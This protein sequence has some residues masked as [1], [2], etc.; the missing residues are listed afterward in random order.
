M[1]DAIEY[2]MPIPEFE[3]YYCSDNGKAYS[4]K[5]KGGRGKIDPSFDKLH[6]L[7]YV[8]GKDGYKKKGNFIKNG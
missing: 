8:I 5:V 3:G 7:S 6:E 4:S 1:I 2:L